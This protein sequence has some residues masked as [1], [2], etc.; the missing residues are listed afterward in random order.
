MMSYAQ[1]LRK[2]PE[3]AAFEEFILGEVKR[4]TRQGELPSTIT[5]I[6]AL[7]ASTRYD[8][9]NAV[10]PLQVRYA[11]QA[12]HE[13][14]GF[15][16]YLPFE[17]VEEIES[18]PSSKKA[19]KVDKPATVPADVVTLIVGCTYFF[20]HEDELRRALEEGT[21]AKVLGLRAKVRRGTQRTGLW[22]LDVA[23][24]D[25]PKFI[26]MD[27]CMLMHH[28]GTYVYSSASAKALRQW[29]DARDAATTAVDPKVKGMKPMTIE[30]S[31][32]FKDVVAEIMAAC[33]P[34][35]C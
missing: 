33:Q 22:F 32:D 35:Q 24:A 30:A 4:V 14:K 27:R 25:V 19:E 6:S 13:V 7:V 21:Q 1:L 18:A 20:V 11:A 15:L 31:H 17:K 10:A 16:A 12:P 28:Q 5:A 3:F 9:Y 23:A 26:A 8:P 2:C 34:R 29:T